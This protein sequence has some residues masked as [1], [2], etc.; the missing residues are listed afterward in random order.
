MPD[1]RETPHDRGLD[2]AEHSG[3]SNVAEASASVLESLHEVVGFRFWAVTRVTGQ[4]YAI[5]STGQAGFPARPGG[6]FPWAQTLCRQVVL[7]RAPRIAPDI[8]SVTAYQQVA[9]AEQWQVGAYLSSPLSV[10][11]RSLYGTLCAVDPLPQPAAVTGLVA[12]VDR[13]A[14]LL[15]TLLAAQLH[16]DQAQR[17]AERAEADALLDPL[18]G[19]VNRRGW[20]LLLDREEQRCQ[21]YGTLASVLM[22]DLDGLKAVNDSHGHAAGD[23]LLR[24]AA[25]VLR[26]A[27]RSSD[28]VARLG[29]DEFAV[30]TVETDLAAARA[31]Q[32]RLVQLLAA[33][34]V[35]ASIGAATRDPQ[36]GLAA[37]VQHADTDMYR[38]KHQRQQHDL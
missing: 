22:L 9:L 36:G 38:A 19:L 30:L 3:Y 11:G 20:D 37:A 31:E 24:R 12:L 18:T 14:R 16:S 1:H 33:A 15:S 6:Q 21:R 8:A 29:G 23:A 4:T 28:V 13:Q 34:G 17:R 26:D 10:D 5:V 7:G 27:V 25:D 35:A 2:L 32:A